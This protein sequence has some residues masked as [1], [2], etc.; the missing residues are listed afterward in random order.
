[1]SGCCKDGNKLAFGFIKEGEGNLDQMRDYI[2][3]F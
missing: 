2:L 1:M 3:I